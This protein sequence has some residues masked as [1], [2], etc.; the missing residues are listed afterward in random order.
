MNLNILKIREL[1]KKFNLDAVIIYANGYEDS[2]MKAISETYSVLQDHIL[3]TKNAAFISTPSYLVSDLGKRTVIPILPAPGEN[4]TII[5]I[6]EKVGANKRVGIAGFFK[7]SDLVK[8]K[9]SF[10]LDLNLHVRELIRFKSDKYI[11]TLGKHARFLSNTIKNL[12]FQQGQNQLKIE[13]DL[14]KIFLEKEY[15]LAFPICI[16]SGK[17]L[18]KST[19]LSASNKTIV[20]RDV[21]CV[22]VGI[23]KDI[24]TTDITRMFFLKNKQAENAYKFIKNIHQKIITEFLTPKIHFSQIID[25]YKKLAKGNSAILKVEDIDFG[26]GIG[27]SLHENPMVEEDKGAVGANIVFTLE[28]TFVTKF[29]LMRIEDMIG[30]KSN[31]MILKLT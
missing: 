28:P 11:D 21:I 1:I 6:S 15:N 2:L 5:P 18:V 20:N 12:V 30:I 23:K 16:T 31:G 10:V 27:F 7:Y 17:D 9:P 22:D 24:F 3:V 14:Y 26:H 19:S 13:K 4:L 25:E 29:G 8:L